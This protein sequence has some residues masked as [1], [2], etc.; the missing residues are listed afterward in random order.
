MQGLLRYGLVVVAMHTIGCS[1]ANDIY[2]DTSEQCPADQACA[3]DLHSCTASALTL[4]STGFLVEEGRW[5]SSVSGPT[6]RGAVNAK[7]ID[8]IRVFVDG[9]PV[10]P[11]A[12]VVD[13]QW[14]VRLP[15]NTI[16]AT[17]KP[18]RVVLT[19]SEGA[20][21]LIQPFALDGSTPSAGFASTTIADE[22]AD[23]FTF[24]DS[25]PIHTHAAA[26]V[27]LEPE[28][29]T[30]F[31]KFGYLMDEAAPAY[32]KE[33]VRNPLTWRATGNVGVALDPVASRYRIETTAGAV[34]KEWAALP[35]AAVKGDFTLEFPITR[36]EV[37]STQ[38]GI[39]L[40]VDVVDWAGRKKSVSACWTQTIMAPPLDWT[41]LKVSSA[42]PRGLG[43][44]T[45]AASP[46]STLIN[47][48][49]AV[50]VF[51]STVVNGTSD[52]VT[53]TFTLPTV[54]A[55][56]Q[57]KAMNKDRVTT[58]STDTYECENTDEPLAG[59]CLGAPAVVE[60]PTAQNG[61][62][63]DLEWSMS[64]VDPLTGLQ[65]V[66]CV[67]SGARAATCALPARTASNKSTVVVVASLARLQGIAPA[68]GTIAEFQ[69][70]SFQYT[71]TA[72]EN[73]QYCST[74]KI[75]AQIGGTGIRT[76]S[77]TKS[78]VVSNLTYLTKATVGLVSPILTMSAG[79][80]ASTTT[81]TGITAPFNP[82]L[83]GSRN[84]F[85]DT[86]ERL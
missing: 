84:L 60:R 55:S 25:E 82:R 71:G 75:G 72:P 64:V 63:A 42:G 86:G 36:A 10:G 69:A 2:C 14:T 76:R 12:E 51:E 43:G 46:F 56:Y 58:D 7:G 5:W 47:G 78:Y 34:V 52:A 65:S 31:S 49:E 45:L 59:N 38:G 33:N 74:V 6:L 77:C 35:T 50:N 85:F 8:A 15:D 23:T 57:G 81:Q 24:V 73:F 27:T 28:A 54:S 83:G 19:G 44:W 11:A 18:V 62:I 29:C 53:V 16:A 48:T 79:D 21:E 67:R 13:D 37:G 39:R 20:V 30:G 3:I 80:L 70:G 17:D 26:P 66:A 4:D 32:G 40:V 9:A 68:V 61:A 41:L 22:K 1:K